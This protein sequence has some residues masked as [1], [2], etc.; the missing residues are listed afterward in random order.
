LEITLQRI[1]EDFASGLEQ[2]DA[3]GP[4]A[5]NV[6]TK[7]P[8]QPG[9]GPHTEKEA[10]K[11]VF[12]ELKRD[13]ASPYAGQVS[14][15]VPYPAAPRSRCDF[16]LGRAPS[17][18]WAAEAKMLRIVGDNGKPN[19]NMVMHM[20]SPYPDHR[21]AVT[22][23]GKLMQSGFHGRKAIIVYAF[24]YERWPSEL[25][26]AAFECLASRAVRLSSRVTASFG[27]LIH[28]VHTR[29]TVFGW[30]LALAS[31]S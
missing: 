7:A 23:C 1:V 11:L 12:A 22:D 17:Y 20:L 6:R 29:G 18:T 4:V 28:P 25:A 19:D 16:C 31:Q 13:P 27:G 21:S 24:D 30:E 9:I 5:I 2:A 26:I 3:R 10:V 14:L 8:F 15:Q